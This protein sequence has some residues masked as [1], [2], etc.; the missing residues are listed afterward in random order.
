VTQET[1]NMADVNS[2]RCP[3]CGK[4]QFDLEKAEEANFNMTS[5][6]SISSMNK[7]T[8]GEL[9]ASSVSAGATNPRS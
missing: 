7:N 8:T 9:P 3:E 6:S 4:R 2:V 1:Q 5:S